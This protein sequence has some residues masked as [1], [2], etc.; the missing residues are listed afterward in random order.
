MLCFNLVYRSLILDDL[1]EKKYF[2][3]NLSLD[4]IMIF[5]N[6][7]KMEFYFKMDRL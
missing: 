7:L 6:I 3:Q 4:F 5:F 2:D 1:E